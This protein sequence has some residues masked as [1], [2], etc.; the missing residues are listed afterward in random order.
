[1]QSVILAGGL[2]TRLRPFTETVPKAMVKVGG[3]PFLEHQILL[4]REQGI[5][6]I[7]LLVCHFAEQIEEFFGHGSKHDVRISY[8][9][10]ETPR[11]TGGALKLAQD[12]LQDVFLLLNGDT[13]LPMNFRDAIDQFDVLS[14]LGLVIVHRGDDSPSKRNLS[15]RSDMQVI[16]F[17]SQCSTPTHI[18][19]GAMVFNRNVLNLIQKGVACTLEHELF[20]KLIAR[21]SL[22]AYETVLRY[23]DMG[24]PDGLKALESVLEGPRRCARHFLG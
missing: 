7:L 2:G 24:T 13:F 16:D 11:G 21:E 14:A 15:V 19:A 5:E 12:K 20:P 9:R 23:Y 18:N 6:D 1:M 4:L 8:S 3:K 22:W 10:E 17:G